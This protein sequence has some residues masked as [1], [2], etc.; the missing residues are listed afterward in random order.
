MGHI[1]ERRSEIGAGWCRYARAVRRVRKGSSVGG[2][3]DI[4]TR[5]RAIRPPYSEVNRVAYARVLLP[6]HASGAGHERYGGRS[7]HDTTLWPR[8]GAG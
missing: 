3:V 7:G 5:S 6:D 2:P 1:H 8:A 4:N